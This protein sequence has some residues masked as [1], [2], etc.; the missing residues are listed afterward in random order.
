MPVNSKD[1]LSLARRR[2]RAGKLDEAEKIYRQVLQKQPN[3]SEALH[4]LGAL[5]GQR[6]DTEA[7]IDLIRRSIGFKRD[8][9]EAHRNL[10]VLLAKQG[11]FDEA[12]ASFSQAAQL[13]PNDPQIHH[14]LAKVLT[15]QNKWDDAIAAYRRI[16]QLKPDFAEAHSEI[17][18][19]LV[20]QGRFDEAIAAYSRAIRLNPDF[21]MVHFGLGHAYRATGRLE[22]AV[23]A[24]GNAARAKPDLLA[25]HVSMAAI[26]SELGRFDEALACHAR[27][28]QIKPDAAI[29]HEALGWIMLRKNE[30]AAAIDHFRRAVAVDPDLISA[31]NSLGLALQYQGQFEEAAGC[32]RR[33]LAIRP[34]IAIAHKHLVNTSRQSSQAEIEPLMNLLIQPNLSAEHRIAAG[35]AV[36]TAL[37]DAERFDE[38]FIHFAQANLLVKQRRASVGEVYDPRAFHRFVDQLIDLFTPEFFEKRRGWG[39]PSELPVFVVGMPRSGTTLV[40]QIAGSHPQVYGAGELKGIAQLS[41]SQGATDAVAAAQAWTRDWSQEA[42]RQHLHRLRELN[43]TALRIIDKMPNNLHRLGLISVLFPRARVIFCRRD[44][45]DT[46]LSCYFQS[47]SAGNIF[48]YDLADC[49]HY[50]VENDRLA[51]HWLRVLPLAMLE[52]RYEDVVADLENQSRRLIDFLGLPW[53]P[54]CLEFYR[55]KTT[56]LTSSVWQVRQPLYQRS[57]GRWRQYQEH[58]GPLFKALGD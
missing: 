54:A 11:R 26:L 49:G 41:D 4:L 55:T 52:V 23:A 40:Q 1:A 21:A 14:D 22:E 18:N 34:D 56:V 47:F 5:V 44:A 43:A 35:F 30:G 15:I 8:D 25:A 46:C 38:A 50:H 51:A 6:G 45:R 39:D 57:V 29:T 37:D 33:M 31:W 13:Q 2:H 3:H 42:A 36:A 7:A 9:A 28:A 24:Y 19:I 32:F 27:A 53:D 20:K 12:C 48:S 16:V 10:G 58:L 17:G